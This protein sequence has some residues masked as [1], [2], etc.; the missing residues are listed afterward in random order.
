M[1]QVLF[2]TAE[3]AP[4]VKA[5]GLGDVA[6]SLPS[7]VKDCDVR[8]ILPYYSC[9]RDDRAEFEIRASFS[10]EFEGAYHN[11]RIFR[12]AW[13]G[14]TH[15]FLQA[16]DF[17]TCDKPYDGDSALEN[18]KFAFFA[19]ALMEAMPAL[20]Y[21]PDI[22]HLNDW[23]SGAIAAM[24]H[25]KRQSDPFFRDMKTVFTIHNLRYQGICSRE[26][27]QRWTGLP[28]EIFETG[29]M[30]WHDG[31]ANPMKCGLTY[32]DRITTVSERYAE[33]IQT[34]ARGEGMC[35]LLHARRE[36][37]SGI[38][39]GLDYSVFNPK[40][41]RYLTRHFNFEDAKD[42]KAWYKANLQR[43]FGLAEDPDAFLVAVISR[44]TE[45]KGIDL[46]AQAAG[47]LVSRGA[48]IL[49]TGDGD[50]RHTDLVNELAARFRGKI[51]AWPVFN[52]P[53]SR[54]LYAG[55][56]ALLMPSRFEPCGLSQLIAMRYGTIP[57]VR[58]TG[59]LRDTVSDYQGETGLGFLFDDFTPEA[60]DGAFAAAEGL[61]HSDTAAWDALVQRNMHADFSWN[62]SASKYAALYELLKAE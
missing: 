8:V 12:A 2:V 40:Y 19:R 15:Y 10:V 56:D 62:V 29:G 54:T 33:E 31:L 1:T 39:N 4:F 14:A 32:A 41:D 44:L 24:V 61:Y 37:L 25:L 49:I 7:A 34:P 60:L 13:K 9:V 58:R 36:R 6:S 28:N 47:R 16:P 3:C 42:G 21:K 26:L 53:F 59:G 46:I 20:G 18:R 30:A 43:D 51:A 11:V 50:E 27:V 22:L 5:G 57:I 38:V 48:Q 45:Q 23:H 35:E 55:A 17:F 52:E